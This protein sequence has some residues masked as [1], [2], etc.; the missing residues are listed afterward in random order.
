VNAYFVALLYDALG[1]RNLAFQELERACD[2][3]STTF[4]LL[5]VD[6]KMDPL[7]KD[8]RFERLRERVFGNQ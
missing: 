7:R 4:C 3:N 5:D 1:E 6:P 8:P 2:E